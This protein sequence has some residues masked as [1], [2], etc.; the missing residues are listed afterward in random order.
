M[1]GNIYTRQKCRICGGPLTNDEK[2]N[3]CFCKKHPEQQATGRF[4]MKFG[5]EIH[6]S[7]KDYASAS[8]YLTGLRYETDRG[9]FD[10][11]DHQADNP[12]SFSN[13]AD[14][15]I[16][17]KEKQGLVSFYHIKR[18]ILQASRY[19]KDTNVKQIK[20]RHIRDFLG[21]LDVSD[22]TKKNTASQLHDFF[23]NY[24]YEEEE[25]LTLA[26]L[27]KFPKIECEL[28][29]RKLIDIETRE[30]IVDKV[31]TD[32][33]AYNP[34]IWLGIDLLCSYGKIRPID[35]RRIKEG[36]FD[37]EYGFM[38][39]WRPSKSKNKK[40]PKVVSIKLLDYHVE[41]IRLIKRQFPAT[42]DVLFFRHTENSRFPNVCIGKDYLYRAW[43][44][45]CEHFGI[46][47]LDLYGGTR[48]SSTTAIGKLLGKRKAR[49]FS[50]HDTN[51]AFERYCQIGEQDDYEISQI[52]AKARGKIIPLKRS[53]KRKN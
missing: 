47:D 50:G 9:T 29:F 25:V 52:M 24:L 22:K 5:N 14:K 31:R 34:K 28:G 30:K 51:Q 17:F 41:E 35:L 38:T 3:G 19:F 7:F 21:T 40:A 16:T 46:F 45:A 37:L 1:K 36:D 49:D 27:P 23:Y 26:Q 32:T 53:K 12:L 15:Y 48:H 10:I 18:F 11:R 44:K 43:K 2:K 6:R 39:V 33:Y 4:Y 20:R 42:D 13:L 8:R